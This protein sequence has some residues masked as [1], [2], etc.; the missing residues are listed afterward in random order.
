MSVPKPPQITA[1]EQLPI[2][3]LVP[4][5]ALLL[6]RSPGTILRD[7]RRGTIEPKP[8]AGRPW[9]WN[10]DGVRAHL[11]RLH[12][13]A[14]ARATSRPRVNESESPLAP[15]LVLEARR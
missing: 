12:R 5:L 13:L 1:W 6:R 8:F 2:V 11:D 15:R 7:C 4:E 3:L 9:R 10:R 14:E